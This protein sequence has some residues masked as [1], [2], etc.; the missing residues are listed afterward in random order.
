M[1]NEEL[2][3]RQGAIN[4]TGW[5]SSNTASIAGMYLAA[6]GDKYGFDM[7]TPFNK[8]SEQARHAILYGTGNERIHIE[9]R[10][11]FGEGSY[12]SPFEGVIPN[13]ERRYK[14]SLDSP[15]I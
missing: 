1:P 7:D 9:Y 14:E 13:L 2:S 6:L 10:R 4:V 5:Q 8:L 11:E 3:L 12:D 15:T